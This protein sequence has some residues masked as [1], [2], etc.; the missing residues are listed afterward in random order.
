MTD[1]AITSAAWTLAWP[2]RLMR[3]ADASRPP[4]GRDA[5]RVSTTIWSTWL[6]RGVP[7][8]G[9]SWRPWSA[10]CARRRRACRAPRPAR[11]RLPSPCRLRP[12]PRSPRR[13]PSPRGRRRLLPSQARPRPTSTTTSP[14]RRV[15]RLPSITSQPIRPIPMPRHRSAIRYFGD[16]EIIREIARGGMGVVFQARQVSLNRHGRARR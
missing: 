11:P 15:R 9:P 4:G 1:P 6:M 14:C 16:Y 3:S 10:T 8:S 2:A 5:N 13:R 12:R 7:P